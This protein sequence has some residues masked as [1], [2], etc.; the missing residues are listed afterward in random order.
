[1]RLLGSVFNSSCPPSSYT[2]YHECKFNSIYIIMAS[3]STSP[4]SLLG[5]I[6]PRL[7]F[8]CWMSCATIQCQVK[9]HR[10][11]SNP[12]NV[13][14]YSSSLVLVFKSHPICTVILHVASVLLV[15]ARKYQK[16]INT[17]EVQ[18]VW[19]LSQTWKQSHTWKL[20]HLPLW[21]ILIRFSA[22]FSSFQTAKLSFCHSS[23]S[24]ISS[25]SSSSSWSNWPWLT[26]RFFLT[27]SCSHLSHFEG[28]N[29]IT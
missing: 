22:S 21:A 5:A 8:G 1:M 20:S 29:L 4:I 3:N 9:V 15:S 23:N 11:S 19:K 14:S 12:Q 17:L 25:T 28:K 10:S 18:E 26:P 27:T 13:F 24:S 6:P 7:G 2:N 16:I